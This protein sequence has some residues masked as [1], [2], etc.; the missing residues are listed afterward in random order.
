[1]RNSRKYG[2]KSSYGSN[3]RRSSYGSYGGY[4]KR[5]SSGLKI[6]LIILLCVFV[7]AG[8]AAA[9]A[10][11]GLFGDSFRLGAPAQESSQNITEEKAPPKKA[12]PRA[13]HQRKNRRANG[14]RTF[15]SM[16]KTALN[17]FP[18]ATVRQRIMPAASIRSVKSLAVM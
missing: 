8:A 10:Y 4:G 16:T 17:P 2:Y 3:Y 14:K 6:I 7:L 5:K 1:M 18:P 13:P 12:N 11:A 9:A 15:L